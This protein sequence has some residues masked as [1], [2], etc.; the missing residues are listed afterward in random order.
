MAISFFF[1]RDVTESF[2]DMAEKR[3]ILLTCTSGSDT[4][5]ALFDQDKLEKIMFNLLSN[6]FKYT[7]ENGTIEVITE[8]HEKGRE[9]WIEIQVKDNGIGI[10]HD[11]QEKIFERFFQVDAQGAIINQG[12]GIGLALTRE[13]VKIHGGTITVVSEPEKGSC[14]TVSLPLHDFSGRNTI[15]TKDAGV[16]KVRNVL[17]DDDFEKENRTNGSKPVILLVED[18]EDFRFYLKDNLVQRYSIVE[19][20]NGKDGWEKTLDFFPNLIVADI[21]MPEMDGIELCRT[22]KHDKRTSHIPIILLTS[23]ATQD[24]RV[25]GFKAGADD[26]ITKP[27]SFEILEL[28]IKNLIAERETL[29]KMFQKQIEVMP[30][31][32]SITSTD[33]KLIQKALETVEKSISNPDFSVEELSRELGMSRVHLYKKLLSITGNTPIEFIRSIR[34]KRAAQL[35]SKSQM[36]VSEI[37]YQVGFN[38]PKYFSKYFKAEFGKLPSEYAESQHEIKE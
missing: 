14:F 28:R 13:F 16:H 22:I 5:D 36:R 34:L 18:N 25:E 11:K 19:S 38:N 15:E 31:E 29:K 35:L 6:A 7:R 33:E 26:Y 20:A 3:H 24:Q 10:P 37:A 23:R 30:S 17:Q 2:T 32:I 1:I 4:L 12:S 9:T 8:I 27:F 21:T